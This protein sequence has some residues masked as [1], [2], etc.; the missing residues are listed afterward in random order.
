MSLT[1][2]NAAMIGIAGAFRWRAM[3]KSQK[4]KSLN[5]WKTMQPDANL[6]MK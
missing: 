6:K 3:S 5:N 4:K 2:D 1:G